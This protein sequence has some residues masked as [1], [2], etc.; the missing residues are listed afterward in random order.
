M[1]LNINIFYFF[2]FRRV[3]VHWYQCTPKRGSPLAKMSLCLLCSRLPFDPILLTLF[4]S[5]CAKTT[6]S[7]MLSVNYQVIKPV[8][9]LGV[10]AELWLEVPGFEVAGLTIL[11]RVVLEI[12]VV[13]AAC[14][15]QP[16]PGDVGIAE[17][18]QRRSDMPSALHWLPQPYQCWSCLKVII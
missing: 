4:T 15:H 13:G 16:R 11:A 17:W 5:T 6:D 18:I 1:F 9:S 2:F 8:L 7:P 3:L 12:C 14:L 10:P